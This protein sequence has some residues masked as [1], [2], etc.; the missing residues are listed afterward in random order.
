MLFDWFS[1]KRNTNSIKEEWTQKGEVYVKAFNEMMDFIQEHGYEKWKGKEPEDNRDHLADE[2]VSRLR[3]A[4]KENKVA[5]FR[6]D[7]APAHT[8][9]IKYFKDKGQYIE[10]LFFISGDKVIFLTGTA[11]QK[12]QAYIL[13]GNKVT[14]LDESIDAIGKSKRGNIFAILTNNRV[15]L[16]KG[17]EGE[18]MAEFNLQQLQNIGIT[19]LI[20][21]NDASA[22]LCITGEGIYLV[23]A[24]EETLVHP[25]PDPNDPDWTSN[26]DM[27]NA[28]L[29]NN[30]DYIIVG[31]QCWGHYVLNRNM[32][33]I[34]SIGPQS[35]YPHFCLFAAGD[36]H[37]ITNSCH[38]YNGTT[39]GV[40][41][42]KLPGL[43]IKEYTEDS[44]YNL[45][46]E[47]MRVYCG[48]AVDDYYILGDAFGSIHAIDISGKLKWRYF[49]GSTLGSIAISD[50]AKTLWVGSCTGMV[51]KLKLDKGHRD[52][53]VIGTG[54]HY[55]E[56]R[57][58]VWKNE[59]I[60]F[61]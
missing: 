19:Q 25:V 9:L 54:Q 20:P 10:Q 39:I 50:D 57:L 41:T 34:A 61:W 42:E 13:D 5:E 53:Q 8:P 24:N 37:L 46:D 55:E 4:N 47:N 38:F 1:K 60:M 51:H 33:R 7:F 22:V 2:V 15:V 21:Y 16:V 48:I 31:D 44:N 43:A 17:W 32:E 29:S 23:T 18:I 30:N 26:I 40:A 45:M 3:K 49:L 59:P 36:S 52:K 35:S 28:A 11:Y 56:F 27:E 6:N 12:R 14:M 58:I